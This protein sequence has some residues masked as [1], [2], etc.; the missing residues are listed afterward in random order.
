MAKGSPTEG[1]GGSFRTINKRAYFEKAGH[2]PH[3]KQW[4]FHNSTARF[5]LPCCGRRFGKS[6]MAGMDAQPKLLYPNSRMWIVG[7]TYDLA[8]KEFRVIWDTMIVRLKFGQDSRVKRAYNKKQGTMYIQ[9]PWGTMLE[10]RSADHPE[11]L[12]G[13]SLNH[14]IVSEAA[15]HKQDTFERYLRAALSDHR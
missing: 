15:K 3:E 12:V 13:E 7:P 11:N 6:R 8:E 1:I 5:R 14:V 10:C 2:R 9:F 4:L